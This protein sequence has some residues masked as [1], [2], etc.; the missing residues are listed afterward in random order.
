MTNYMQNQMANTVPD[1]E[2]SMTAHPADVI[3]LD[4]GR[5]ERTTPAAPEWETTLHNIGTT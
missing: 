2:E 1:T 4:Q 3:A 5:A